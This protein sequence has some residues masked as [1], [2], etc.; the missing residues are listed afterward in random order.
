MKIKDEN[1]ATCEIQLRSFTDVSLSDF[2]FNIF[3]KISKATFYC[4]HILF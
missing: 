1:K 4:S 2:V 3:K